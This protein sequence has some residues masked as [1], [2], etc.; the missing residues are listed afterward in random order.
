LY[1]MIKPGYEEYLRLSADYNLIPVYTDCE[2]DTET[3]NTVYLKTVGDS[4]GCLLES[5][6]GGENVGR[7][8]FICLK[9]FLTYRGSN[10]EGELTYPG[11]LKKAVV[12]SPHKV[13]QG[14]MDSYRIPSFPELI[15]FSGGAVGYIGYDVVRSVEELPE[16]LP[17]DDSL[18]LCMMFFPSVIL[19][20]DHVCRS[21]KIVANVPVGDDPAQSYERSLELIKAVKQ[22]LQKPLVLPGDN[23]E[24]EKRSPAAGLEEIVSEP[25]KE[26]FMEMVEQALEYI[27]AGDIIQVVLS[28]RYST[29]QREEPFSIFRKLRR[30]NPSPYMY[31]M[32]F[33]DPVVVGSS[34]EMLVKVHNGQVLTHPIAGT[35]PRGKNGAQDSELAKDLLADEKERAEHLMLV[36]LGRNDIGRV[37]LPGTV[38]VAR[39]MEIEKFSHVMHIV[40]TV[41]GRLLPEKTPLDAL[42]ACF[43]AGTV[44]GAPKI[45]AMS[46][47]EELEPMR[48][49]I[50]AGAVGYIGFNNTMDTAIAIRTI[51]VNKGKCYV[52]AGAGIVADS[53]P[54]KE[55]VETQNKAGALLR[56]LGY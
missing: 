8:S 41:Q 28:R 43:P 56:V 29:P 6:N 1:I 48:R 23:F 22:D 10:T 26:L 32:D 11:G 55:Y 47:I 51:V 35:R 31:F 4:H 50:Y 39:F 53:E 12:G 34:P 9:P 17:E 3:P 18:P 38:E 46:I 16:L 33:G 30:L 45:R 54:E 24:Q 15:E 40:S 42:M 19:C 21:M 52:Q 5:V 14:L 37:S 44:S 20:Y 49:G 36:D 2:A 13:L 27:R 25:G 7:H